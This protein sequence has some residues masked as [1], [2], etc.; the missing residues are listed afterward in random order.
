MQ[1][2]VRCRV[3]PE[4]WRTGHDTRQQHNHATV[5]TGYQAVVTMQIELGGR[6]ELKGLASDSC[7]LIVAPNFI[8]TATIKQFYS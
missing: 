4:S 5:C 2:K 1:G 8:L 3:K 6:G 7:G